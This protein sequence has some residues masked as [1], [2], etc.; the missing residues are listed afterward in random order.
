MQNGITFR[1]ASINGHTLGDTWVQSV[2]QGK[3]HVRVVPNPYFITDAW[4]TD[5]YNRRMAFTGLPANC[6]IRIFNLAGDLVKMIP[7][8]ETGTQVAGQ[9]AP[10]Q[11]AQGG[12]EF[13]D[14]L[15]DYKQLI[16]T[17]VYIYHIKSDVGEQIG[18]FAIAR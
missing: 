3:L 9:P 18:K 5:Q 1:S 12:T 14:L 8:H 6:E 16:S 4:E 15:N 7:H 2:A 10:Q 13:W 11:D 17:G